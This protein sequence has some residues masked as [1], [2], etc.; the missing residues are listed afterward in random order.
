MA[1]TTSALLPGQQPSR[2]A[3]ARSP[4]QPEVTKADTAT[5]ALRCADEVTQQGMQAAQRSLANEAA[6][7]I[8]AE[9]VSQMQALL[10][11]S[12]FSIDADA[13]ASSMLEFFQ[14]G[15]GQ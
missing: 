10:A 12:Q 4:S 7:D 13:L 9:K 8:D 14:T 1:I 5:E 3:A 15:R 2:D 6:P 11:S